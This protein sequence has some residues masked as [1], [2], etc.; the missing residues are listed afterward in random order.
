[1]GGV[2]G[3]DWGPLLAER[4]VREI[5]KGSG[6]CFHQSL[7]LLHDGSLASA[8]LPGK[9]KSLREGARSLSCPRQVADSAAG[10]NTDSVRGQG[11]RRLPTD[12]QRDKRSSDCGWHWRL[13]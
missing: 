1:M 12:A 10:S 6:R 5:I 3:R 11:D 8:E 2:L 4:T 9:G 7:A 13:G